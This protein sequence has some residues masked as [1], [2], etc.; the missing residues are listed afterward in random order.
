MSDKELEK[1]T[2]SPEGKR[3]WEPGFAEEEARQ[4]A[5]LRAA[6]GGSPDA[7]KDGLALEAI[8]KK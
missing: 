7:I 2:K 1:R 4:K 6:K 5:E 8:R 3:P